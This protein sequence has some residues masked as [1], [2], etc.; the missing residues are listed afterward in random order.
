MK[1]ATL[2][3]RSGRIRQVEQINDNAARRLFSSMVLLAC[4]P[5]RPRDGQVRRALCSKT[6]S[7]STWP[8]AQHSV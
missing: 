8:I 7:T 2:V 1:V 3:A 5:G 6:S 4:V